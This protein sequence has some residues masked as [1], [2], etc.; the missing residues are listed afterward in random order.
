ML[1]C[2]SYAKI[3]LTRLAVFRQYE[4]IVREI[5]KRLQAAIQ[6]M[7]VAVEACQPDKDMTALIQNH[8]T[9][10]FVRASRSQFPFHF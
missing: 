9:G 4:E 5:P 6:P 7:S 10:P 3:L 8:R 2:L 1:V